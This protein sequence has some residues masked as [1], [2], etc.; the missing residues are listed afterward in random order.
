MSWLGSLP[1]LTRMARVQLSREVIVETALGLL[2]RYGLADTTMRRVATTLGVAPG[3]LYWHIANKQA[4][5]AAL[6][7]AIVAPAL[8]SAAGA[9]GERATAEELALALRAAL[10]AHTDGAEVASAGLSQPDNPTWER[11]IA[12]F[13]A[14]LPAST[15]AESRDLGARALVHLV[16]GAAAF[17]QARAQLTAATATEHGGEHGGE[18]DAA[19]EA[20]HGAEQALSRGA[21][22]VARSV[23]IIVAGLIPG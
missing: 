5:I 2:D 13:A 14:A 9:P 21:D 3:A 15:D 22:N 20:A 23:R 8:N 19:H 17:E 10:L 7:D 6:A 4:L 12:A 1:E 11:I 16:L 18:H